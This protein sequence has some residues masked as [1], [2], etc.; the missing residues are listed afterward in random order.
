MLRA[1]EECATC[2]A[3]VFLLLLGQLKLMGSLPSES[4]CT[5]S[6]AKRGT[7]S[8]WGS[9]AA[10]LYLLV[11]RST[12]GPDHRDYSRERKRKKPGKQ[13]PVVVSRL[14]RWPPWTSTLAFTHLYSPLFFFKKIYFI[15]FF[16]LFLAALGLWLSLVAASRG[17]SLLR[18]AGFSSRG[19]SCCGAR[20]LGTRAQ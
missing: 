9:R 17:Y 5:G 12:Q 15:L 7:W 2:S 6:C 19:F 20:A 11:I 16:N 18:C 1:A 10:S 8:G 3:W 4:S 14:S 13:K